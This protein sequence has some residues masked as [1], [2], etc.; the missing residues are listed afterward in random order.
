MKTIIWEL[1][2]KIIDR[3]G[4]SDEIIELI[5][6][7]SD[8]TIVHYISAKTAIGKT[9]LIT[10]V[11]EK[12]DQNDRDII[13]IK[14][15]PCNNDNKA[16]YYLQELFDG[17]NKYYKKREEEIGYACTFEN[18]LYEY[19]DTS[20]NKKWLE[21]GL[22]TLFHS[23]TKNGFYKNICHIVLKRLLKLN[24]FSIDQFEKNSSVDTF[25]I[26]NNYITYVLKTR[27]VLLIIEN[28]QNI[29][30]QSLHC[31]EEWIS[32][33]LLHPYFIL[34][35]T[36][37]DNSDIFSEQK[38]FFHNL[39]VKVINTEI[40]PIDQKYIIDIVHRNVKNLSDDLA[41]NINV[42]NHYNNVSM[43]NL[44]EL[45]DY[46][47]TYDSVARS[48][49]VENKDHE[50]GTYQLLHNLNNPDALTILSLIIY[51]KGKVKRKTA[52]MILYPSANI[53]KTVGIL[54]ELN[55][56]EMTDE[57]YELKH[58]SIIDQ[59]EKHPEEFRI[60]DNVLYGRIKNFY[61]DF[62]DSSNISEINEAWSSLL[63]LYSKEEPAEIK[64]LLPQLESQIIISISPTDSLTYIKQLYETIKENI[65]DN[66]ELLFRLLEVCFKLEL[67]ADGYEMLCFA[68][69]NQTL[70]KS[71]ML[72]LHKLSYLSAL[73]RHDQVVDLFEHMKNHVS[74][75]SRIGL[76]MIL[77]CM[78][79][80]RYTGNIT[81][82]HKMHKKILN[83]PVYKAYPE[84]A[85]FL[86][87]TNIYLPNKKAIKYA[88]QS[89]K[90]FDK[91]NNTYQK[92]KSQITYAKLLA[93]LGRNDK[94]LKILEEAEAS[95]N[96][97][98]IRGNVLWVNKASIMLDKGIHNN[99]VWDLLQKSEFTAVIPYDKLAIVIVK[100][101]WC[102][103]NNDLEKAKLLIERGKILYH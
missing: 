2:D 9:S 7:Y 80:F 103:E 75:E 86:R 79:S 35:F 64:K 76:N 49:R 63:Y 67:Y 11:I 100:L 8:E 25:I 46:S 23:D 26:K 74:L 96:K 4:D 22:E 78:S 39:G 93:G 90:L 16:W 82:C 97:N 43:G 47:T 13:R 69:N 54:S 65:L 66:K 52:E 19:N 45:I 61:L 99:Q 92:G 12:Y 60:I 15:K 59:W 18:Y 84:Y 71:K 36:Q 89:V 50:N 68:E 87:L 27:K 41:F 42:V 81:E 62:L 32:N 30:S 83:N 24:E 56:I 98:T 10:K 14:T 102:Y 91:N 34:E 40:D 6:Q 1:S 33:N 3:E 48:N 55:L 31:F 77:A 88:L 28:F 57:Y 72:A 37:A 53:E 21:S 38:N 58:A 29:D 20:I 95:L 51:H 73:D 70:S 5:H 17:I 44:K 94:A 101:A 85:I